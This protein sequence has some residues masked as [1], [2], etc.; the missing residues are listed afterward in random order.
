MFKFVIWV[1]LLMLTVFTCSFFFII[2]Y[3]Y[4]YKLFIIFIDISSFYSAMHFSRPARYEHH[5]LWVCCFPRTLDLLDLNWSDSPIDVEALV[6]IVDAD[7]VQPNY[8]VSYHV[9]SSF[10]SHVQGHA[11]CGTRRVQ[12]QPGPETWAVKRWPQGSFWAE[13]IKPLQIAQLLAANSTG[14]A[15]E[16]LVS[17]FRSTRR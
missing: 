7:E 16:N 10:F 1:E 3:F 4:G 6:L 11:K 12:L 2:H 9:T 8:S 13:L 15:A 17:M 5:C 14:E